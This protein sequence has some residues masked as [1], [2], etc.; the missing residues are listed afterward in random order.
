MGSQEIGETLGRGIAM[1]M[2]MLRFLISVLLN[3]AAWFV[4][5]DWGWMQAERQIDKMQEAAFDTPGAAAPIPPKVFAAG[6]GALLGHAYLSRE[7][8]LSAGK[9]RSACCWAARRARR[10]WWRAAGAARPALCVRRR[11]TNRT[12]ISAEFRR[13]THTRDTCHDCAPAAR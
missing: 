6:A 9:A 2:A 12:L 13:S 11:T 3:S 4:L 10:C 1:G 5:I 7:L 8:R